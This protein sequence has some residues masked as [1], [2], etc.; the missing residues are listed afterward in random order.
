MVEK[1]SEAGGST[2]PRSRQAGAT[3]REEILDA[4]HR[5]MVER[6]LANATTKEIAR[7]AG[8]S[9]ATLYKHFEGKLQLF[10]AVLGERLP[11][12]GATVA[13]LYGRAGEGD[14]VANL[15]AIARSAI[16]FYRS[17]FPLAVSL[18]AEPELLKAHAAALAAY[19][20]VGPE[21]PNLGV[22]AYFRAEQEIGRIPAEVDVDA[23]AATLVG[24]C[25]QHAF[26]LHFRTAASDATRTSDAAAGED[27]AERL[28]ATVARALR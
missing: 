13:D 8:Y 1:D 6:G 17:S 22:A 15:A 4:A 20:N 9:E 25:F 7:A 27:A 3:T 11:G 10:V 23:A 26:F 5:V 14:L 24:A 19:D 2:R 18:F 16:D 21:Q 12:F 28:A